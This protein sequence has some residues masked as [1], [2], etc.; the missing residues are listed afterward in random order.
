[1]GRMDS[2]AASGICQRDFVCQDHASHTSLVYK[3]NDPFLTGTGAHMISDESLGGL[4]N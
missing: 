3:P 2:W 4:D 1:M